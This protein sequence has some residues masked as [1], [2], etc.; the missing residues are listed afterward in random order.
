[1]DV[2]GTAE[3]GTVQ[4]RL[5]GET[6]LRAAAT[7]DLPDSRL[8]LTTFR[9]RNDPQD[10]T[11]AL[12]QPATVSFAQGLDVSDLRLA[13][14]GQGVVALDAA[15]GPRRVDIDMRVQALPLDLAQDVAAGP[16]VTGLLD[17]RI[18]ISGPPSNPTG[19]IVAT[20]PDLDIP[21][22]TVGDLA[23]RLTGDLANERLDMRLALEGVQADELLGTASIPVAFSAQGIPSIPEDEPLQALVRWRGQV[24][25]V[26][27]LVPVVGHRLT[28]TG[29]G[30]VGVEG[31]L[32]D[33]QLTAD[34]RLTDGR[35]ENL[36]YGTVIT[37]LAV[38]AS[39]RPDGTVGVLLTG[40]DGGDGTVRLEGRADLTE[41][42][43]LLLTADGDLRSATLVRRDD[44]VVALSGDLGFDG[45]LDGGAM[46]AD[47]TVEY[48]LFRL[49]N[50]FGGGY[51]TLEVVEVGEGAPP[52][53]EAEEEGGGVNVSLDVTVT[54]PNQVYVRGRGL[55]SEW[56]GGIRVT[57]TSSDP[58]VV[59]QMQVV[60]G[61]FDLVGNT[62]VFTEG[63]VELTG[64]GAIDPRF[65]I[66]AANETD[67]GLTAI[68]RVTG[69][70]SSPEL[71]LTSRPALPQD[72]VMARVL[73]GR[74]LADLGPVE[75]LQAAN[76]VRVLTG[77]GGGGP[78]IMDV[79]RDTLG[80]DTLRVG[81]GEDGPAVEIGKYITENVYVGVEQGTAIDSGGVNVEVELTPS[82][83]LEG[84]TTGRG[85]DIGVNWERDY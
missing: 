37:D 60:R 77:F 44:L 48:A 33:P 72:E 23:L 71:E 49:V 30:V 6:E 84:R 63:V 21:D 1:V 12:T 65:D 10:L 20:I 73:F 8:T 59:G 29:A 67:D 4:A 52:P 16:S 42:G 3:Q 62:F 11:V 82:I 83:T 38:E 2:D 25:S 22:A 80:V 34:L 64:G 46:T 47:L 27:Q 53:A 45:P 18:D 56:S 40:R 15:L 32:A 55:E 54:A 78:G 36:E 28:G 68:I 66:A 61:R 9:A 13:V 35:Y 31:T 81:G 14:N 7:Y 24:A 17:A 5:A 70:A 19:T 74:S 26:W 51:R 79:V 43:T 58:V 69:T 85:S 76:A 75:A 41:D 39:R 57:G 50:S